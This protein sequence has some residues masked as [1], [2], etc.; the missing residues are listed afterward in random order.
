MK[1][2]TLANVLQERS[3]ETQ[4]YE[5][6]FTALMETVRGR[7]IDD[8]LGMDIERLV[9]R[10]L[11]ENPPHEFDTFSDR[12]YLRTYLGRDTAT[13]WEAI[14]M[15]WREGNTTS[16]HAHPQFA[17]YHFADGQFRLEIFEPAGDGTA[18]RI[19]DLTVTAPC[20]FH[21]IGR[22]RSTTTSTASHASAPRATAC[23]STPTTQRKGKYIWKSKTNHTHHHAKNSAGDK[24]GRV[25]SF[26]HDYI[27]FD[28]RPA[29]RYFAGIRHTAADLK[30]CP[31]LS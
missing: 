13:G 11:S 6:I 18:R 21:A 31:V 19:K 3:L 16:I 2:T 29:R 30:S 5:G 27:M 7:E 28:S 12:S 17:G 1:E 25:F 23:M 26:H 20:A 22:A 8:A 4:G 10:Y 9:L 24:Q 14:M 15:S